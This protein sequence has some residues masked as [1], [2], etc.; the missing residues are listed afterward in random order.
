MLPPP[1]RLLARARSRAV[2]MV[3]ATAVRARPFHQGLTQRIR[4]LPMPARLR[5]GLYRFLPWRPWTIEVPVGRLLLGGQNGLTAASFARAAGDL[6]W[7]STPVGKG[8]HVEM[9]RQASTMTDC[10]I[11]SS[12][13]GHMARVVIAATGNYFEATDDAGIVQVARDFA[14]GTGHAPNPHSPRTGRS[15]P[16]V[17]VRVNRIR[18]S[19]HFQ[20]V[21]GHHRIARQLVEGASHVRARCGWFPTSTPVQ[22]L[23]DRMTWIG[24]TRELYQ[25]V[26]APELEESWVVVRRC[27]DRLA[28]MQHFLEDLDGPRPTSYV[29]VA[30]CYGWFV[31]HMARAGYLA[32]GIERDPLALELGQAAYG[33]DPARIRIGDAVEVLAEGTRQWDVVSCLSLLHHF[34]LGRGTIDAPTFLRLLDDATG[35]VLFLDTGQSH[36]EWLGSKLSGWQTEDIRRFLEQESSF[37]SVHDLGPDEDAEGPYVHNY[38]RHLFACVRSATA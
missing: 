7:P 20:V 17:E 32:E 18:A 12:D 19:H 23:L 38:G 37:D 29:D 10:E 15:R 27:T 28:K 30:S 31:A 21:D 16:G 5:A 36:E 24:G 9:L 26:P 34:A 6:W 22:D 33:L 3:R 8:P 11:L 35:R 4:G 2:K 13:Y 25:P 1:P 14:Q